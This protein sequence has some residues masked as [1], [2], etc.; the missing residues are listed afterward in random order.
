MRAIE[1]KQ[2]SLTRRNIRS[3]KKEKI[4]FS[5][6]PRFKPMEIVAPFAWNDDPFRDNNWVAQLQMWR[7]LDGHL[8][9]YASTRDQAWLDQ[10]RSL[11][12]DWHDF[13][14]KHDPVHYVWS[15]MIVGMRAMKIA[16]F[17]ALHFSGVQPQPE[18]FVEVCLSLRT[19]HLQVLQNPSKSFMTNHDFM[20]L[21]GAMALAQTLPEEDAS[22]VRAF[23]ENRL[24]LLLKAQFDNAGVH[25]E[26]SPQYQEHI[27]LY[28]KNLL[29]TGWFGNSDLLAHVKRA[30][31]V[32]PWFKLPDGR[33][34]SI[35]DTNYLPS[36]AHLKPIEH[37]GDQ[38]IFFSSGYV[39]FKPAKLDFQKLGTCLFFMCARHALTHKHSDDLSIY[40]FEEE[41]ILIDPGKF[42]YQP[43]PERDYAMSTRAHNTLEVDGCNEYSRGRPGRPRKP[44]TIA[45]YAEKG[46]QFFITKASMMIPQ[47]EVS[48]ERI[49]IL[50][51]AHWLLVFD[52]IYSPR[53]HTYSFNWHFPP[54]A[55]IN[56]HS[57]GASGTLASGRVI[58]VATHSSAIFNT[59]LCV[60]QKAP[61]L[62]GFCSSGY[63]K[64][65]PSPC[66]SFSLKQ[67]EWHF[68]TVFSLDASFD[69]SRSQAGKYELKG[70]G[71]SWIFR[72]WQS[73]SSVSC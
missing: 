3:L 65:T 20:D 70:N 22:P 24:N 56:A 64:I 43:G 46:E 41:D 18:K 25:R 39:I 23:V 72:P 58:N 73:F 47:H 57:G 26:N 54:D 2:L 19:S 29:A 16:W 28:L 42:A 67:Q 10:P 37:P 61:V 49:V 63:G 33:L 27:T 11:I 8:R 31:Y 21:H 14:M 6:D 44:L 34:A 50:Y 69:I 62:Q 30:A 1:L 51:P 5:P 66:L 9:A 7:P 17:I 55:S 48:H 40:W 13:Y 71:K 35:G 38:E 52:K 45:E 4:S 53:S 60:G 12:M 15:D 68:A 59:S 36:S 32:T